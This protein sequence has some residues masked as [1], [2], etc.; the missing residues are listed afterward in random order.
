MNLTFEWN[1]HKALVNV[2]K[3]GVTFDEAKT[4]FDDPLAQIFDDEWHSLGERREII[5]GHSE[6]NRLLIVCF[7]EQAKGIIRI[8][9][10]R[11]TT[12]KEQKDYEE[13]I[14]Y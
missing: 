14:I 9:S 10:S 8:F 7:T 4:V 6:K 13:H 12:K 5:I 11:P 1:K 2:K 3:H